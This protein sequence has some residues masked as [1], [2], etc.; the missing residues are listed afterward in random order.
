M[1][2]K[3]RTIMLTL[4][5]AGSFATATVV[6]ALSQADK[7]N[8]IYAKTAA[9]KFGNVNWYVGGCADAQN[10]FTGESEQ[11]GVDLKEGNIKAAL[12]DAANAMKTAEL[13]KNA[14]CSIS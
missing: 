8:S 11:V 1:N 14:G 13:A 5:A 12:T 10:T 9:H 6:P 3:I 7:N 4:I 2:A